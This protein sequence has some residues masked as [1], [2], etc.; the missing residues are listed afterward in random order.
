[1]F[2]NR[3]LAINILFAL[4]AAIVLSHEAF[5]APDTEFF[6]SH[7]VTVLPPL[8]F[9]SVQNIDTFRVTEEDIRLGYT[10]LPSAFTVSYRTDGSEM[11]IVEIASLDS[12]QI[13]MQDAGITAYMVTLPPSPARKDP[14]SLALD[15]RVMLP[16]ETVAGIY[17][18][19]FYVIPTFL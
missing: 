13:Y 11:V 10:D 19:N 15:L 17:P 4:L 1:M 7:Q 18:L 3:L 9:N 6:C 16:R 5:G 14:T 12:E 8:K 2:F